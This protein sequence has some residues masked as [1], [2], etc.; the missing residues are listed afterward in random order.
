MFY[1]WF[2]FFGNIKKQKINRVKYSYVDMTMWRGGWLVGAGEYGNFTGNIFMHLAF[3]HAFR[4]QACTDKFWWCH[5]FLDGVFI[6]KEKKKYLLLAWLWKWYQQES[7]WFK[8]IKKNKKKKQIL[9]PCGTWSTWNVEK[10]YFPTI[11][12]IE[13]RLFKSKFYFYLILLY[14]FQPL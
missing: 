3:T 7:L 6:K 8:G 10:N 14:N 1:F 5:P 4:L 12:Q 11:C 9:K 13:M 2:F